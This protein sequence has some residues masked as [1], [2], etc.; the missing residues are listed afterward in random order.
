MLPRLILL[1]AFFL[2]LLFFSLPEFL[3][4]FLALEELLYLREQDPPQKRK[5]SRCQNALT[6]TARYC[7]YEICKKI[8]SDFCGPVKSYKAGKVSLRKLD[9]VRGLSVLNGRG[10]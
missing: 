9:A 5:C 4:P 6:P 2:L 10:V 7:I 3:L 1:F 8:V